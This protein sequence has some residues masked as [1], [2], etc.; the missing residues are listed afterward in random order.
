MAPVAPTTLPATEKVAKKTLKG[1]AAGEEEG[2]PV[3]AA[4]VAQLKGD[5][6]VFIFC[7]NISMV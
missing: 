3:A 4:P 7:F 1:E 5:W 6:Q 2:E